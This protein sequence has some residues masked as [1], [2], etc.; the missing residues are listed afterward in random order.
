[1]LLFSVTLGQK[2]KSKIVKSIYF[3]KIKAL[4]KKKKQAQNTKKQHKL[5][6]KSLKISL[7]RDLQNAQKSK[8]CSLS[9]M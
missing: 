1:M 3:K 6:S 7:N 9:N 2:D 4:K 8:I 5:F